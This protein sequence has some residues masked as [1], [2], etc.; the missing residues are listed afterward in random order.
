MR[1]SR[2][3]DRDEGSRGRPTPAPLAVVE[4]SL[5]AIVSSGKERSS[6]AE[7]KTAML[8]WV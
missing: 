8:S 6:S 5:P 2:S 3:E 4:S 1:F 7:W